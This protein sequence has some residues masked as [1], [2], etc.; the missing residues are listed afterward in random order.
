MTVFDFLAE[1]IL[2]A[3]SKD[4]MIFLFFQIE[5]AC[6]RGVVTQMELKRLR[7]L[8]KERD[9]LRVQHEQGRARRNR[10]GS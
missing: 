10:Y 2:N 4:Q 1:E 8:L 7:S 3:V 5:R 6:D 9:G